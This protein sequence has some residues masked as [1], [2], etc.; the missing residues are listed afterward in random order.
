M[1]WLRLT[2]Q[3]AEADIARLGDVSALA[4]HAIVAPYIT[5]TM[6][7][8]DYVA[9][10]EGSS[11]KVASAQ[12]LR[13]GMQGN[14]RTTTL[15]AFTKE[16]IAKIVKLLVLISAPGTEKP[17]GLRRSRAVVSIG[18]DRMTL[19]AVTAPV[20]AAPPSVISLRACL[21]YLDG[22]AVYLLA[23][24]L[25]DGLLSGVILR[26]LDECKALGTT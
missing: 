1:F 10:V 23:V 25:V 14:V 22:P 2:S 7:Q 3:L 26:H 11:D 6:G 24:Q 21:C 18:Q 17:R 19:P 5:V 4:E 12:L 16:E 15:K 8:Y 20:A 13:L 9:I